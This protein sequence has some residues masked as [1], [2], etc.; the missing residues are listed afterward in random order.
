MISEMGA[1][2]GVYWA[3]VDSAQAALM[4]AGQLPPSPEHVSAM[5]KETFVDKGLLK[6][7]HVG[8]YRDLFALYKNIAHGQVTRIKGGDIDLWQARAEEF[9]KKMTSIIND[10]IDAKNKK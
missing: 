4:T 6:M 3:M 2:E 8:W 7:E 10:L 1:I 9:M 5:L